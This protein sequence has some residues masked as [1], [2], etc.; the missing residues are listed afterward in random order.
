MISLNTIGTIALKELIH[1]MVDS[2]FGSSVQILLEHRYPLY[3]TLSVSDTYGEKSWT[4][5]GPA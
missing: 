4:T 2:L 5:D 1:Y 3:R